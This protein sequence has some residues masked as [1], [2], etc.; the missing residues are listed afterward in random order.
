MSAG[1]TFDE[2]EKMFHDYLKDHEKVPDA[3]ADTLCN[4]FDGPVAK[5]ELRKILTGIIFCTTIRRY[6]IFSTRYSVC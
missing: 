1:L 5:E 6:P 4:L 3:L 2:F